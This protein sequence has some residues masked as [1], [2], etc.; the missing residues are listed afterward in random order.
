MRPKPQTRV[1]LFKEEKKAMAIKF[2]SKS[3]VIKVVLKTDS[4]LGDVSDATYAEYLKT[5]NENLLDFNEGA[6]PT[7]FVMTKV[8]EYDLAQRVKNQRMS[9]QDGKVQF[10]AGY[11]MEEVR[12][13]LVR[14]EYDPT[15]PE[16]DKME[17]K[18]EADG[19]ASKAI[20]ESLNALNV[21]DDLFTALTNASPGISAVIKKK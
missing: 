20:M 10:N 19:G 16:E 3:D 21:L 5:L 14:I 8:I 7:R 9:Y 11:M 1:F 13:A 18:K 6:V 17:F 12:C 2:P 4:A 15:T